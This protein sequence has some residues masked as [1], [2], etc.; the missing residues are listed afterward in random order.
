[1]E[2]RHTELTGE[3]LYRDPYPV[4]AR[5]RQEQPVA[6]F[7]GT[8]EYFITR[9]DDC[10]TIGGNDK[11]FGPSGSA[12]RPEARVMGM[13]NVLTM[14]GE[15]HQCLREGIDSNLTQERVRS[16]V[17][18]LT[19]PVVQRY[20]DTI[21]R[22][23]EA[24]LTTELFEPVSVR[25]IGDVIGLTETPNEAL[26]EW[27]HAMALGLQNIN[28]DPAVWQRL[29]RAL[30]DIDKQ[31]G[32]LYQA[33]LSK[34]NNSLLS[35]VMYGGLPKGEVRSWEEIS[36]T[37]RVIILGG[38]QEPG[39]AAANAC[40]G[41]LS[42]PDQ[43][44]IMATEPHENAMRAFDEGLR[45]I[46]PI[47]VTPR[48]AREDFELAGTVIPKG[49]SVAIVMGSANRDETRFENADQFDMFRK[50]KQ[51]LAF[52]FRPHF[53]SGHFLSRAMG[54]IALGQAFAQLPNLRLDGEK[55][56]KGK[57]WRF[58]GISE[59]PAKWDA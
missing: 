53:C 35:H 57:G 56:M 18:G 29:D 42:N 51:H 14:S 22:Q 41:L 2:E 26:V 46:A 54:E 49:S 30:A 16:F 11:V 34:P 28:N 6:F 20:I 31:M 12:D 3:N 38:L 43:A 7:E 19:R 45:W 23:N 8:K 48:V 4:Y 5:L 25:C 27:F 50:K 32:A 47:G 10:R 17:E 24:N 9:F 33:C 40:A 59:L 21:K 15:E 44:K 39:H 58:R 13:P 52:G 37:M 55:E 1:M 36:P